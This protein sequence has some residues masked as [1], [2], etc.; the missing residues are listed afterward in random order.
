[1][2]SSGNTCNFAL[3][4]VEF[5][6]ASCQSFIATIAYEYSTFFTGEKNRMKRHFAHLSTILLF[7]LLTSLFL[8]EVKGIPYAHAANPNDLAG[9]VNPLMGT[10]AQGNT[11]P[12]ATSPFGM[13]QW[14]PDTDKAIPRKS[15][16]QS[17]Y[18]YTDHYIRG[19]GLTHV[20]GAGCRIGGDF[21]FMPFVGPITVSPGTNSAPYAST[22]SHT[23]EVATAGYYSVLLDQP[24]VKTE[25]T[26]TPHTGFGQFTYPASTAS[27]MIINTG[28]SLNKNTQ[29]SVLIDPVNN[30]VSGWALSGN[31]CGQ[32]NYYKIY[33]MAQFNVPFT[34]YGTW[35]GVNV[36]SGSISSTGSQA[37]AFVTFN[38]TQNN[39]VQVK[40]GISYVSLQ[41]ALLNLQTENAGWK[42]RKSV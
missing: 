12:G 37:G 32:G 33:F 2:Q 35:K 40:V 16:P 18:Y 3:N 1:M 24:G 14:S 22:F 31:F 36:N 19:F 5:T 15:R 20:S 25:L 10:Q 42:D 41:N 23:N 26:V 13:V 21:P 17:G 7:L 27:T 4:K 8:F 38:T 11:F 9:Y 39:I 6:Q 29:D 34:S 28:G 30:V